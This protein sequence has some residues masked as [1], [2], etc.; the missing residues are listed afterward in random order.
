M[1]YES[2]SRRSNRIIQITNDTTLTNQI[3]SKERQHVQPAAIQQFRRPPPF[4]QRFQKH[5][6]GKQFGKFLEV[7]K[8]LHINILFMEV[9]ER[10][11]NYVK[12]L[13]DIL[14]RK[15]RLGEFEIVAL[16]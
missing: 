5:K 12:F 4:L 9:L 7:L 2:S 13:K 8:Q 6:Q 15:M 3:R 11:P 14:V 16:I 10:M 1:A